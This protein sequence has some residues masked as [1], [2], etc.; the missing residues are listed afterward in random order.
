MNKHLK[1]PSLL[2][3]F[4]S[5]MAERRR[6]RLRRARVTELEAIYDARRYFK[7]RETVLIAEIK[8][9]DLR[10]VQSDIYNRDSRGW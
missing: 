10:G 8:M 6:D 7:D 4:K 9:I 1:T 5:F 3:Q 2:Q